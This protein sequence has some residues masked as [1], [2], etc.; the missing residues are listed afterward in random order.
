MDT[1]PEYHLSAEQC[2]QAFSI[3]ITKQA[4][5]GFPMGDCVQRLTELG[6]AVK[7][8]DRE[9]LI[10]IFNRTCF[11]LRGEDKE[12][13]TLILMANH[14]LYILQL[15]QRLERRDCNGRTRSV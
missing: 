3:L 9:S 4:L 10:Y 8:T 14:I 7:G 15:E 11:V 2:S 13:K 5:K 1:L 12:N 6:N